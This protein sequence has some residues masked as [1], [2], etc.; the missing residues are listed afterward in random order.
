MKREPDSSNNRSDL[1]LIGRGI[2]TTKAVK[3]RKA[4]YTLG[5]LQQMTKRDLHG[6]GLNKLVIDNI[7]G[8]K[9]PAPPMANLIEALYANRFTC[10]VC[11]NPK[12][13]VI[14][15]HIQK[16][17]DT[18]DHS[19]ENLAVLCSQDHA[20]AHTRS[21]LTRNLDPA[22]LREL[23][24]KWEAEVATMD[25]QAILE[26][27]RQHASAW[28]Y[29]NHQRLFELAARQRIKFA[30]LDGYGTALRLQM[31]TKDGPLLPRPKN[32]GWMYEGGDG[33]AL[34]WYVSNVL[35]A[36]LEKL[37]IANISDDLERG[38]LS[39]IVRPG[40]F[41]L[42]QGAHVFS[43]QNNRHS[44][45]GQTT[46]CA[47]KANKVVVEFTFDRWEATSCSAH[48]RWLRGKA[49]V[50]SIIRVSTL[51]RTGSG[52]LHM[53]GTV[54]AIA[55]GF[56]GLKTREYSTFP[57]RQGV[58]QEDDGDVDDDDLNDFGEDENL[59]DF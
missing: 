45:P 48:G 40:D 13:G 34:Y 24:M 35:N 15:H 3:L 33:Q 27:S 20:R 52:K 58:Y 43:A 55:Q 12:R 6:L 32:S 44:G 49:E 36:S 47:R 42:V 28:V 5:K 8:S 54:I 21:E 16:W 25:T 19:V 18:R 37:T 23:K 46:D 10:C 22:T 14:V 53:Q 41:V 29:F 59:P 9:R 11:R 30:N 38:V 51:S 2:A 17:A 31:C 50:T 26:Q 7:L 56:F 57:Y 39:A 4:G 1:A